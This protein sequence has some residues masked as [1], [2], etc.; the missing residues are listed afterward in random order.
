MF[1]VVYHDANQKKNTK[2]DMMVIRVKGGVQFAGD[3]MHAGSNNV[4]CHRNKSLNGFKTV[5]ATAS[6]EYGLLK[7]IVYCPS[8][9]LVFLHDT[10]EICV[11]KPNRQC[12]SIN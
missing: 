3:M 7:A 1:D 2:I 4:I 6:K 12:L 9:C 11:D 8:L 10:T 5:C